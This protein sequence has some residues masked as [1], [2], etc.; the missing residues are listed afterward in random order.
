M[1]DPRVVLV[2]GASSG[3]GRATAALLAQHGYR[4]FG[5]SRR[6]ARS[7]SAPGVEMLELDVCSDDSVRACVAHVLESARRIDVLVNNAGYELA[8][9]LEE[10]SLDE[11]RAQLETN[12]F[13]VVRMVKAVLP[14]MRV[15]RSGHVVNVSSLA[16]LVAGPF[17][18]IYSAS[19]FALEGFGEALRH[20]VKP[21]GIH[22]S[23]VEVGF[24]NTPMK[25]NRRY[26]AERIPDYDAAR[27]NALAAIAEQEARGPGGELVAHT[28]LRITGSR[29]PRL[30]YVVGSQAKRVTR[31]RRF[32][33]AGAF[34]GGLRRSFR[35]DARPS[36]AT[37]SRLSALIGLAL[38]VAAA[39]V[40]AQRIAPAAVARV[41]AHETFTPTRSL[42]APGRPMPAWLKRG[43]AGA[44]AGAVAF[45]LLGSLAS[46]S[47]HEPAREALAGAGA[48]F[49]IVGGAVALW[50][51]LCGP[52][53]ASR[54]AGMCGR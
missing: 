38:C 30:R 29:S 41:V 10:T 3:N 47:S 40:G 17:M 53:S 31:L 19:K 52:D 37:T 23:Q 16:G 5:T 36:H 43:L 9:A 22:V 21:F 27:D 35:L 2:T 48:G 8:G 18:G 46:D 1:S 39:P 50:Q 24:L 12:F 6:P 34:E 28:I 13:G 42:A 54:R 45:P 15:R 4:V 11:A 44:G 25:E 14:A 51:G 33:P 26:S 49:V 20:E 32:L 7:P